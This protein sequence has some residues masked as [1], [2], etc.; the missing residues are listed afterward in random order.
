MS[1]PTHDEARRLVASLRPY[2]VAG[3]V[4]SLRAGNLQTLI[5]I[6]EWAVGVEAAT[7]DEVQIAA[8]ACS[9]ECDA[10]ERQNR[11][12]LIRA[13]ERRLLPPWATPPSGE[14]AGEGGAK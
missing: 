4:V 14:A 13:A 9:A 3:A 7:D 5:A 12:R 2:A 11:M 1:L 6:A 10:R 8:D